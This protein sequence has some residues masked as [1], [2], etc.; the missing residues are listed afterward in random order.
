MRDKSLLIDRFFTLVSSSHRN[1]P[2]SVVTHRVSNYYQSSGEQAQR[3]EALL[4][5]VETVIDKSDA[6]ALKHFF[7]VFEPAIHA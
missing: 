2:R 5:I 3:D 1:D 6:G 4:T 7:G